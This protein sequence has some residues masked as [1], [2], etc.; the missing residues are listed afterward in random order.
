MSSLEGL[1]HPAP[2]P[3]A[4]GRTSSHNG[5]KGGF[6]GGQGRAGGSIQLLKEEGW[7]ERE[8]QGERAGLNDNVT[9]HG[10]VH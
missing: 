6:Y 8:R 10:T 3:R 5:G 9:M 4:H 2:Q 7:R 1:S